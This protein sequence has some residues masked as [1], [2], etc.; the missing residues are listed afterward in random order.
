MSCLAMVGMED[1]D[2][3]LLLYSAHFKTNAQTEIV[4]D[5]AK[6]GVAKKLHSCC[7]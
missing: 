5:E 6:K 2:G 3:T 7:R 1:H 4:I